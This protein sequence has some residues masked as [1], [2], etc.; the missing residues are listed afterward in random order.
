MRALSLLTSAACEALWLALAF[1]AGALT[2]MALGTGAEGRA[3]ASAAAL[4]TFLWPDACDLTRRWL[5][6]HVIPWLDGGRDG[7]S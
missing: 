6:W 2:I 7:R 1:T 4:A 5:D 3:L